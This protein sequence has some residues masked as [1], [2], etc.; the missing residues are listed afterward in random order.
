MPLQ[1]QRTFTRLIP[2]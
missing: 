1:E 2:P